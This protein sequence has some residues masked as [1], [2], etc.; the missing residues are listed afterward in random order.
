MQKVPSRSKNRLKETLGTQETISVM[1][2]PCLKVNQVGGK[3][4]EIMGHLNEHQHG[5]LM[6]LRGH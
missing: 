2:R 6:I 3:T 5:Y 1:H 4:V